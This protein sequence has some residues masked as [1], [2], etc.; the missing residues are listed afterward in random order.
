MKEK[1]GVIESR[2]NIGVWRSVK[3]AVSQRKRRQKAQLLKITA[4]YVAKERKP[5]KY[6]VSQWQ[7]QCQYYR[8]IISQRKAAKNVK[9]PQWRYNINKPA[10]SKRYRR[11]RSEERS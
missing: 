6:H 5:E 4:A 7:R 1:C 2:E 3:I 8:N 11:K 10:R 9:A